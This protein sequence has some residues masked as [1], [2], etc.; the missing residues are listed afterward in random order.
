MVEAVGVAVAKGSV[1][2][3]PLSRPQ[4]ESGI[5]LATFPI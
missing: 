4:A 1:E 5:D 2:G 3:Q